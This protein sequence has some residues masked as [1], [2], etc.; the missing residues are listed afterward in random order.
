[1]CAVFNYN[2]SR[3]ASGSGTYDETIKLWDTIN[4]ECLATLN[5]HRDK[6]CC[7]AFNPNGS[8][9]VSGSY[10]REVRVWTIASDCENFSTMDIHNR[11]LKG[12]RFAISAVAFHPHGL[13]LATADH[14][15]EARLWNIDTVSC[16]RKYNRGSHNFLTFSPDGHFCISGADC[17]AY[18]QIN[19]R[20]PGREQYIEAKRMIPYHRNFFITDDNLLL[21]WAV[22]IDERNEIYWVVKK[23]TLYPSHE[24]YS[25]AQLALFNKVYDAVKTKMPYDITKKK[26]LRMAYKGLPEIV[27]EKLEPHIID[28]KLSCAVS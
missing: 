20:D 3:L 24:N 4:G 5:G 9:L 8:L 19:V 14:S 10:D 16:V 28:K 12:H 2:G 15:H 1:M 6:V 27:Q 13:F 18:C 22:D 7:L 25:I 26:V 23:I 21:G 11:V 17:R